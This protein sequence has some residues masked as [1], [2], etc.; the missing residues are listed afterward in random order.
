MNINDYFG[1]IFIKI[2]DSRAF[3]GYY[4][5]I[6]CIRPMLDSVA[7]KSNTTGWYI[8]CDGGNFNNVRISYF[9]KKNKDPRN[10]VK[11]FISDKLI[12]LYEEM[13]PPQMVKVSMGYGGEELRFRKYLSHFTHI[14]L[15]L[16]DNDLHYAQCLFS[17]F[18]LQIFTW[19]GNS[20][21]YFKPSFKNRSPYYNLMSDEDKKQFLKDLNHWPNP[22]GVDWAH[23]FVNMILGTDWFRLFK[24]AHAGVCIPLPIDGINDLLNEF[25]IFKIPRDWEPDE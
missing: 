23:M 21:R 3:Y 9:C 8:N 4:S 16:M 11:K 12:S 1:T 2:D 14:G 7:W 5:L 10:V 19:G 24:S 18:R 13:K 25:H 6:D 22:P 15:D 20:S 17:V